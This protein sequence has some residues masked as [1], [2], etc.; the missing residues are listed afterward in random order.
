[1]STY[2]NEI[3]DSLK[4]KH[5]KIFQ[6]EVLPSLD[7]D[8]KKLI[9]EIKNEINSPY[10]KRQFISSSLIDFNKNFVK[11]EEFIKYSIISK[12]GVGF[13][14]GMV[15][16]KYAFFNCRE[17]TEFVEKILDELGV[18]NCV[19][20]ADP[21]HIFNLFKIND[22]VFFY[23]LWYGELIG[24]F[25]PEFYFKYFSLYGIKEMK[26][27]SKNELKNEN[28]SVFSY[29]DDVKYNKSL[30]KNRLEDYI[31][32]RKGLIHYDMLVF[33]ENHEAINRR[34]LEYCTIDPSIKLEYKAT[35]YR[36]ESDATRR[37]KNISK[38]NNCNFQIELTD[39]KE[40][41][42]NLYR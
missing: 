6:S 35:S 32:N 15:T 21:D 5:E 4:E 39:V 7:E 19:C 14:R 33:F 25:E 11:K 10:K 42:D 40:S 37:N 23:D 38:D 18:E 41:F 8:M 13:H 9:L 30:L 28:F 12:E 31:K 1:M 16:N 17:Y 36:D 3:Y 24:K 26:V 34:F 2:H 27:M 29:D 20:T 22:Q